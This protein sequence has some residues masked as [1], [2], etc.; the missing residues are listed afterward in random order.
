MVA[1]GFLGGLATAAA[2]I[3]A[4]GATPRAALAAKARASGVT[5]KFS[6]SGNGTAT[7]DK[8]TGT[9]PDVV[10]P[11]A[12]DWCACITTSGITSGSG[13]G[14]LNITAEISIDFTDQFGNLYGVPNGSGGRCYGTSGIAT[15][16]AANGD[17]MDVSLQGTDC[18]AV[19]VGTNCDTNPGGCQFPAG[20]N[21]TYSV[22][23]A[24]GKFA[25]SSNIG[26][27]SIFDSDV[28][29]QNAA[30]NYAFTGTLNN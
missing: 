23:S 6:I 12:T 8:D 24:T 3:L 26:T 5:G 18:D 21:G 10:C 20:I 16:T 13:L 19:P 25:G 29:T 11:N 27:F 15:I 30:A 17:S 7:D 2:L 1:K 4:V 22:T 9:C 14:N 28:D